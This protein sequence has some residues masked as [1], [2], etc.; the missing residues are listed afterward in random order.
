[1]LQKQT[2]GENG[3]RLFCLIAFN[4]I[5]HFRCNQ[6]DRCAVTGYFNPSLVDPLAAPPD[7]ETAQGSKAM[8]TAATLV[9]SV[10]LMTSLMAA[11]HADIVRLV[12]FPAALLGTWAED[13]Q[14]CGTKD[15]SNVLIE[16]AKYGDGSG[17]CVVRWIVETAGSRGTNYAVHAFCT[18]A[19]QPDKTQTVN[20]IIRPQSDGRA[21]M[22]RSFDNLK[23]YTRCSGT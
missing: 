21:V 5:N 18:S 17:S 13:A 1:V 22:G 23:T 11:G 14:Q 9:I 8:R 6:H 20:I 10:V 3:Y 19:S 7:G 4:S 12:T 15:K 2:D 16:P